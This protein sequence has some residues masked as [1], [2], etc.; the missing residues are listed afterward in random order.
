MAGWSP[1]LR[2]QEAKELESTG[3]SLNRREL[4][5]ASRSRHTR[6]PKLRA[7]GTASR[8][9]GRGTRQQPCLP[10]H[11]APAGPAAAAAAPCQ[12][13]P[14]RRCC[15]HP[16]C[17]RPGQPAEPRCPRWRRPNGVGSCRSSPEFW[18]SSWVMRRLPWRCSPEAWESG[19]W[20]HEKHPWLQAICGRLLTGARRQG[21]LEPPL[22]QTP[23]P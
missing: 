8:N 6:S 2:I 17:Q 15:P 22:P 23:H 7:S 18:L 20:L 21:D 3:Q 9:M 1:E 10:S 12:P 11:V 19:L 14:H 16:R 5:G 13:C 4:R